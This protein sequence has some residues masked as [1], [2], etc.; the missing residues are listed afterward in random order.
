[1]ESELQVIESKQDKENAKMIKNKKK[2]KRKKKRLQ[3]QKEKTDEEVN[4][5]GTGN[6]DSEK[7]VEVE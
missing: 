7:D 5:K 3:Q 6:E 4:E 2:K 1:M